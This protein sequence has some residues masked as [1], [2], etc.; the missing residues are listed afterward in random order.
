MT[1]WKWSTDPA[2]N[3]S[4]DATCPWPE[5]M[6]PAQV[7]DSSRGG[8]A[9]VAK[10]RDDISG[11]LATAGTSTAYTITSNQVFDTLAHMDGAMIAFS[12]HTTS[13]AAPTLNVDGLGAKPLRGH[14]ARI[15]FPV[16][17]LRT[18]LTSPSTTTRA[19]NLSFIATS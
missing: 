10:Y 6:A 15:S 19:E 2:T 13:G 3:G 4:A 7:N 11:K 16:C 8:M 17:C 9:A 14:L 5:G 1:L 12:P 18:R